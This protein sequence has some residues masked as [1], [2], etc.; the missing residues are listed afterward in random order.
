MLFFLYFGVLFVVW[1]VRA[2]GYPFELDYGEGP[3]LSQT[4]V[5]MSGHSI[6][7]DPHQ[8]P[9]TIGNYPPVYHYVSGIISLIIKSELAAG[10]LVSVLSSISI[11]VVVGFVVAVCSRVKRDTLIAA[12]IAGSAFLSTR[13]VFFWG[14][15]MRV[16]MLAIFFSVLGVSAYLK[17]RT[18]D[19]KVYISLLF[20]LL[21]AYTK[22]ST[23]AGAAACLVAEIL[24]NPNRGLKLAAVFAAA[25][26]VV[27]GVVN[28]LTHGQF[29]FH[30]I[31]AN[32]NA[33]SWS[34]V[35]NYLGDLGSL[36]SVLL[37]LSALGGL[38]CI[39]RVIKPDAGKPAIE[40]LVPVL[41]LLFAFLTSLTIGKVGSS[42]NYFVELMAAISIC[43]GIALTEARRL[44]GQAA[45]AQPGK[46]VALGT[47]AVIIPAFLIFQAYRL[48]H[49]PSYVLYG[50]EFNM[51]KSVRNLLFHDTRTNDW[52]WFPESGA[53]YAGTEILARVMNA[54]G[55]VI[56]EV[57]TYLPLAGKPIVF[58]PFELTQLTYEQKW[59]QTEFIDRIWNGEFPLIMLQFDVYSDPGWRYSRFTPEVVDVIRERY[60]LLDKIGDLWLYIPR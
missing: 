54:E 32:Q 45:D 48:E 7:Q 41:Y 22:Q 14:V 59:D 47:A 13:P 20:F 40:S 19:R 60:E 21:A 3:I 26:T 16:D 53:E 23:I 46:A 36:H 24:Y 2:V 33:F 6:Y 42:V 34:D 58:Q 38:V 8:F 51:L 52:V 35:H 17:W 30:L 1:S 49:T 15:L 4:K 9:Y 43:L 29:Y 55:P 31:K 10:R 11:A 28:L 5:L 56:S 57:M 18:D 39:R 12:V 27:F 37:V 50:Q 25:G 44:A